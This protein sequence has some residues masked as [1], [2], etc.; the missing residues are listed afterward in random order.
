MAQIAAKVP[1][2]LK[3]RLEDLA[4]ARRVTVSTLIVQAVQRT[5]REAE[6]EL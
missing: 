6:T 4:H 2:D 1:D 5:L 3:R